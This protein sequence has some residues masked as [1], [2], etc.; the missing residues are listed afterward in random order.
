MTIFGCCDILI[1]KLKLKLKVK[2]NLKVNFHFYL[3]KIYRSSI[4][5]NDLIYILFSQINL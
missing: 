2:E 1:N 4:I 5:I 3:I